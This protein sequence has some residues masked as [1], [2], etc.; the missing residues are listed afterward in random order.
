M[1]NNINKAI[2]GM[3]YPQTNGMPAGNPRDS[4][5]QLMN[6]GNLKQAN[7]NSAVGGK[8]KGKN[9]GAITIPQFQPLYQT[10]S[11]GP[12]QIIATNLATSTQ[13]RANAANDSAALVKKGGKSRRNKNG[14]NPDWHWGCYSGGKKYR[15]AKRRSSRRSKRRSSRK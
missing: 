10:G 8:R 9:G 13:S 2:P 15:T 6:A 14:G 3:Y 1:S 12:N 7:L 5:V 11:N 4:S